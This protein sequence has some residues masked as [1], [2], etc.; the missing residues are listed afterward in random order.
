M[1][2]EQNTDKTPDT[3]WIDSALATADRLTLLLDA[4]IADNTN[5]DKK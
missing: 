2:Q 4:L 3:S 1:S 5:T